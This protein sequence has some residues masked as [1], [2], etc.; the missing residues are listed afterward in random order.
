MNDHCSLFVYGTL[1]DPSIQISIF[2]RVIPGIPDRLPGYS[3]IQKTFTSGTYPAIVKDLKSVTVGKVLSISENEI[4]SADMYE[5]EEYT[6]VEKVLE[7]GIT[8]SVYIPVI[9]E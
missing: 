8:A 1:L 9:Q 3:V 6:R 5:G 2:G 4:R 7:S